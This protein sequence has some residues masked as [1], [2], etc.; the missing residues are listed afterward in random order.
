MG[1]VFNI[2][3]FCIHDGPGIR[4]TVFLKGCMLRCAWCHNPESQRADEEI[5]CRSAKCVNC[6]GCSTVCPEGCHKIEDGVHKFDFSKCTVC[7]KCVDIC[8]TMALEVVGKDYTVENVVEEVMKDAIFY[9]N[10]GGGVTLSGGDPF[11]QW[12][13]S[14]EL[15]AAFKEKGLHTAMETCGLTSEEN[16]R[17]S[18]EYCDLYLFD[19]KLTSPELHKEYTGADNKKILENIAILDFLGKE[20]V[21]RCPIIPGVNDTEEHFRGIA[22][23]ADSFEHITGVDLEPYHSLGESKMAELG[24]ASLFT[25]EMPEK[26]VTEKWLAAISPLCKTPVRLS[27]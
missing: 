24:K 15:L 11:F 2:Q 9:K 3:R 14:R 5:I 19:Y 7:R 8:P 4:T 21:L 1:K 22:E 27:T 10:S 12:D 17:E 26:K 18:A 20:I 13:F 6:G 25:A 16:I 23:I